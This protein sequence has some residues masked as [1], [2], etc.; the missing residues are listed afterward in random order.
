MYPNDA[1]FAALYNQPVSAELIV[2]GTNPT[3]DK[4]EDNNMRVTFALTDNGNAWYT[5]AY[6]DLLEGATAFD[7]FRRAMAEGGYAYA[8]GKFVT[9]V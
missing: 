9:G 8:G 1:R 3:K 6:D 2:L 7:L 5:V 4:P